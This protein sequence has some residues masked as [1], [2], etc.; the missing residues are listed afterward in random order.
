MNGNQFR[1]A[2]K[3]RG[4]TAKPLGWRMPT[5]AEAT[6]MVNPATGA[7]DEEQHKDLAAAAIVRIEDPK[8]P[9]QGK[10]D[11]VAKASG[12][13]IAAARKRATDRGLKHKPTA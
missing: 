12:L 1:K 9:L 5:P 4:R 2:I 8:H 3:A 11:D 6:W 13:T 7:F 10:A